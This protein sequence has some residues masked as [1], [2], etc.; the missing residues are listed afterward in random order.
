M[1]TA[2]QVIA[3]S[4]GVTAEE[5]A[6]VLRGMIISGKAQHGATATN[7]EM[8][9]VSSIFAKYDLNPFIRE[10]HA[11]VSGGK[12]QVMI[13]F[14]GFVKIMN[15]Q[16]TFN[17]V[18]FVDNFE[19]SELVSV[20]TKIHIKGRD[21][22]VCTTEYMDEAYQ[23]NSAA[24]KKFKKRMLRNKSLAQCIRI[25]FGIADLIDTDEADRVRSTERDVTPSQPSTPSVDWKALEDRMAECGDES[26]LNA[27]C[28]E[29]RQEMDKVGAW[30]G[31]NPAMCSDMKKRHRE[32]IQSYAKQEEA[33]E[34][35]FT[36]V[37]DDA[38]QSGE[39]ATHDAAEEKPVI[40]HDE[41]Y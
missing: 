27:L 21:F 14:D 40:E 24:W 33:E 22:P 15:R 6:E 28:A 37:D 38:E 25:A 20:T 11:F 29:I 4:T 18:E 23:P 34:A 12:L 32:R 36:A 3:G 17:G 31:A 7:A 26:T 41:D 39:A 9:V 30:S 1:S 5:V 8:T 19:G 2:L 10:G 35:N 13:G 16:P